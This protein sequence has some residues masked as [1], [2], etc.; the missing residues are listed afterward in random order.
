MKSEN[1]LICLRLRHVLWTL[2]NS[3]PQVKDNA[4]LP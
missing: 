4:T 3:G 2:E 1:D